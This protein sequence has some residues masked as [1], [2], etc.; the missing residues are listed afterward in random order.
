GGLIGRQFDQLARR[1]HAVRLS[2]TFVKRLLQQA[3]LLPT[4]RPRGRHRR[5]R[6]PRPCFGELLHLDGSRHPWLTLAPDT[7]STLLAVVDDATKRLL[8]AQLVAGGESVV[9][10][11]TALRGG[12]GRRGLPR[13]R[14]RAGGGGAVSRPPPGPGPDRGG[15]TR[16]GPAW[17]GLGTDTSSASPPRGGGRGGGVNRPRK[18]G[19]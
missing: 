5:R 3:G 1:E 10:V 19:R 17:R 7:R 11:M 15:P 12:L 8:Y 16:A 6:E 2:Y 4:R 13:G 18:V 9:A 14:T